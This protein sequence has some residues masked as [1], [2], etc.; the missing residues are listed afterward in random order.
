MKHAVLLLLSGAVLAG[1][2]AAP[3]P[4]DLEAAIREGTAWLRSQAKE[5]VFV[6]KFEGKEMPSPGHTALALAAVALSMPAD[7]RA[8]DP[9]VKGACAFLLKAQRDD[10]AVSG[11]QYF[12]NYFT[13]AA[14]MALTIVNDPAHAAARDK[15]KAFL[16]KLQRTEE[17]RAQGGFGYNDD[18]PGADLSNAQFAI[19]A[20]RAAGI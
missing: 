7:A 1:P 4:A 18:G 11:G 2:D 20:L 6:V 17:G 14:L 12:D 8:S 15:M 13:S 16:L 5:G 10:G 3:K 9:W 19:E